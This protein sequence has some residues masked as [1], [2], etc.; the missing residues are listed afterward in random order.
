[1]GL[2]AKT[3][4]GTYYY[5]FHSNNTLSPIVTFIKITV[6]TPINTLLPITILPRGLASFICLM[7]PMY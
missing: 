4:A 5:N 2:T 1:M 7:A 3:L 6:F